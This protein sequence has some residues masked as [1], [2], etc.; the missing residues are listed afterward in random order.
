LWPVESG[1]LRP[2]TLWEIDPH[3]PA[4]LRE[5]VAAA[6]DIGDAACLLVAQSGDRHVHLDPLVVTKGETTTWCSFGELVL[7][8]DEVT[9]VPGMAGV[10]V[11]GP[12]GLRAALLLSH[13]TST[14]LPAADLLLRTQAAR[15]EA[16]LARSATTL[17]SIEQTAATLLAML[18]AHEPETV[19]HARRVRRLSR[20]LG[21][22]AGLKSRA[23]WELELAAL[24]HDVG[25]IS[26]A[27]SVLKKAGPLSVRDWVQMRQHPSVGERIVRTMPALEVLCA[28]IRHHHERWDGEG[29]PDRLRRDAIPLGARLLALADTYEVLRTG[30]LYRTPLSREEAL[31]EIQANAGAQLDPNLIDLLPP[32]G[33][34]SA[35]WS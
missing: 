21:L 25:K 35:D 19:H 3:L 4:Q 30:R 29:Y 12:Y 14:N 23:L 24:L 11:Q 1:G 28:P 27:R 33:E 22:A 26:I 8:R 16:I 10:P 32:L 6:A 20:P 31:A 34:S 2:D 5:I 13:K 18:A 7:D 15:L 9:T 17:T